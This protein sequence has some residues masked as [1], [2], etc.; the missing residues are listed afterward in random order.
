MDKHEAGM[1]AARRV[2]QYNI[3]DAT[4]A[5]LI[6]SAYLNPESALEQ[7]RAEQGD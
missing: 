5:D 1:R 7:L 2:A 6:V 3:G 4:W